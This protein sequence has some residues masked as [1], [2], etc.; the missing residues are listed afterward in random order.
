MRRVGQVFDVKAVL[1][2]EDSKA[3]PEADPFAVPFDVSENV[4]QSCYGSDKQTIVPENVSQDKQTIENVSQDL[5]YKQTIENVSQNKQTVENVSQTKCLLLN[6]GDKILGAGGAV[7][8]LLEV[9][10]PAHGNKG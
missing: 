3:G 5:S 9:D 10:H 2:V 6:A 1:P 7:A 8:H 4:S